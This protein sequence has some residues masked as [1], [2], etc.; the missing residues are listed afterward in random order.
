MTVQ[1][2]SRRMMLAIIPLAGLTSSG[3]SRDGSRLTGPRGAFGRFASI[4]AGYEHT[5]AVTPAG[6][7]YCWGLDNIGQLGNDSTGAPPKPV[8]VAGGLTFAMVSAGNY[9]TCGVTRS[10]A[11]Y[12]WGGSIGGAPMLGNG[13]RD[14]NARSPVPVSGGLSFTAVSSGYHHTCG[15]TSAGAAY[16]WGYNPN[17]E[18]GNGTLADTASPVAVSGGI[19]FATV[20]VGDQFTC[21]LTPTGAAYCWGDNSSGELGDGTTINRTTP[22]PVSEGL[23][24]A[25]LSAG[26]G[27]HVC[28]L[29]KDGVAYCWGDNTAAGELGTGTLNSS[30]IP[31]PVSGGLHFVDISARNGH[32]CAIT[33]T[34]ALYCWGFNGQGQLGI[35]TV[36]PASCGGGAFSSN[37]CDPT[38]SAVSGGQAFKAVSAGWFHTCALT[39]TGD[40]YCWGYSGY[41]ALGT[42]TNSLV[43]GLVVSQ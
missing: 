29:T 12:C 28:G 8:A 42:T 21:G 33:S 10:G 3:C 2:I 27:P 17:G 1:T 4:S 35:G 9:Y 20:S 32:T 15:V 23:A 22:V 25:K 30:V 26:G 43:P 5:C 13:S 36:G 11:A 19:T 34:N 7:A 39:T 24:F 16:C 6:A 31:V 18:L 37:P 14:G 41:G 40:A 38:P